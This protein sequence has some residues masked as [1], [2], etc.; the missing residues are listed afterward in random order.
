MFTVVQRMHE[1]KILRRNLIRQLYFPIQMLLMARRD[2]DFLTIQKEPAFSRAGQSNFG[3]LYD[4]YADG[5][6]GAAGFHEE[7]KHI[8]EQGEATAEEG[9][10]IVTYVGGCGLTKETALRIQ[11]VLPRVVIHKREAEP[12]VLGEYWY[13]A[14]MFGKMGSDWRG[15]SQARLNRDEEGNMYDRLDI[16]FSNGDPLQ[17]YFDISHLPYRS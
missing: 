12:I 5:S 4:A 11:P 17:I 15:Q 16:E 13:L 3:R 1:A 9:Q 2:G 7:W 6:G 10:V 8:Q 14:Y